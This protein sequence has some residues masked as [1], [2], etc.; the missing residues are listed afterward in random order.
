MKN[1][2][3]R[4][5]LIVFLMLQITLPMR[6][7][8]YIPPPLVYAGIASITAHASLLLIKLSSLSTGSSSSSSGGGGGGNDTGGTIIRLDG[9]TS[10]PV[11]GW[12]TKTTP[13]GKHVPTPPSTAT[14]VAGAPTK[15]TELCIRNRWSASA[16]PSCGAVITDQICESAGWYAGNST[17]C[18]STSG[19]PI[20]SFSREVEEPGLPSCPAGYEK[21]VSGPMEECRLKAPEQVQKPAG[22]KCEPVLKNGQFQ[23]D[24][25][26]PACSGKT[27]IEES[28]GC[29]TEV[30]AGVYKL[31]CVDSQV[32]VSSSA[33]TYQS[34]QGSGTVPVS[35]VDGALTITVPSDKPMQFPGGFLPVTVDHTN[36]YNCDS[37]GLCAP[38]GIAS[39]GGSSGGSTG[40]GSSGGGSSGGGSSSGGS[41][42]GGSSSGGGTGG[43]TGSGTGTG[44]GEGSG[45][46]TG[47]GTGTGTGTSTGNNK[48]TLDDSAFQ[49]LGDKAGKAG[50][51]GSGADDGAFNTLKDGLSDKLGFM[52]EFSFSWVPIPRDF[53]QCKPIPYA[54]LGVSSSW[55]VCPY[56]S[57]LSQV[58]GYLFYVFTSIYLYRLFTS[59]SKD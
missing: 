51:D 28:N 11:P 19:D 38:A 7:Y 53:G 46:G 3:S 55:D 40:G 6:A 13:D 37:S 32:N 42:G 5:F 49:G 9:N 54:A 48:T 23:F 26:N 44:S 31:N 8:A 47:A 35:L 33:I 50:A 56:V 27:K 58:M 34:P 16:S 15:K 59:S 41:S 1:A 2:L 24:P 18:S 17:S 20:R 25:N 43:G 52:D 14:K 36:T 21:D 10:T 22:T 45:S 29:Q 4:F 30:A 39:G 57:V 12:P